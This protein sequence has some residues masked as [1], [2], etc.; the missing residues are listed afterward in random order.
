MPLCQTAPLLRS[1]PQQKN[2]MK[3]LWEG[4]ASTAISPTFFFD[5]LGQRNE[6]GG[7]ILGQ[8]L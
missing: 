5:V 8:P 4:C 6:I 3:Y 7:I 2:V 1:I